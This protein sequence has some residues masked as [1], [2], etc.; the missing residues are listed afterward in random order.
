MSSEVLVPQVTL[1]N[2]GYSLATDGDAAQGPGPVLPS[3]RRATLR[4]LRKSGVVARGGQWFSTGGVC[5]KDVDAWESN[6]EMSFKE[7]I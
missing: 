5:C 3:Q 6:Q 7:V 4:S 2:E 1:D